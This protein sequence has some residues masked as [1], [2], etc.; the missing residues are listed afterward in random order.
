MNITI[1]KINIIILTG[2]MFCFSVVN[3]QVGVNT[4]TPEATLDVRAK[5]HLGAVT[6]KDGVLVPRVN[7]LSTNGSVNG[8]LV[9]LI[10]DAGGLIKGF[11]YWNGTKWSPFLG[12]NTPVDK[13]DDAWANSLGESSVKLANQSDGTTR[14][15]GTEFVVK[16]DGRIGIGTSNPNNYAK[17]DIYSD[18]QGFLVPRIALSSA[19]MDLNADGDNNINNQPVGLMVYNTS[20]SG[21][22]PDNVFP[23]YYYWDGSRWT[24]IN[25]TDSSTVEGT[26]PLGKEKSFTYN[27]SY[28]TFNSNSNITK[29]IMTGKEL[30]NINS[31]NSKLLSEAMI[32]EGENISNSLIINGLRL[33]FLRDGF[34]SRL[35]NTTSHPI[36]YS[37]TTWTTD[38]G[39]NT[40]A[41]KTSIAPGA[42][43]YKVDGDNFSL[44]TNNGSAEA[45]HGIIYF[46]SGE[47]YTFTFY[48]LLIDNQL[49]GL[50]TA[51]R[52]R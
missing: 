35:V 27:C 7:D 33:D 4:K 43:C 36:I 1:K 48:L 50:T 38:F 41:T 3:G 29:S 45:T 21:T 15:A 6:S 42:I 8:Q 12:T 25:T 17:L 18:N 24:N 51:R 31:T 22:A 9:Y 46:S 10:K 39:A 40:T 20:S 34:S 28:D 13:T 11:Y 16:D 14:V 52:I 23:G 32:E 5:N 19:L 26:W 44:T 30:T 2:L 47:W 37:L 49:K